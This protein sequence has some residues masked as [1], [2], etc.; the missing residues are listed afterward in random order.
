MQPQLDLD[1]C[2]CM[3]VG[4]CLYGGFCPPDWRFCPVYQVERLIADMDNGRV[5][6]AKC[7]NCHGT[8]EECFHCEKL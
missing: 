2:P 3:W 1:I 5:C 8:L 4:L 6:E 7:E